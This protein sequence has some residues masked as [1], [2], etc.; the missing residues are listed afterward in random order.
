MREF[1]AGLLTVFSKGQ[2]PGRL[3]PLKADRDDIFESQHHQRFI[4]F[5]GL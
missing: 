4:I 3:T 5:T 1:Y 2:K